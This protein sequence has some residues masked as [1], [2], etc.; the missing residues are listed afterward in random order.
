MN[1]LKANIISLNVGKPRTLNG[2]NQTIVTAIEKKSIDQQIFLAKEQ[3]DGD[4]QADKVHH[5]GPD[6]AVCVYSFNHYPY[7]EEKLSKKLSP[8]A[9]GEN[10]TVKGLLED[11]VHIGDLFRW[12]EAQVQ[13]S[14]PRKPCHK[15]AKRFEIP[16][17]VKQVSDSG[18]T[19]FYFRVIKEG[20]VSADTPL[21][22]IKRFSDVSLAEV[23]ETFYH[24]HS[25]EASVSRIASIPELADSWSEMMENQL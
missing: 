17:L 11:E 8:G 21:Q 19:G 5:G 10:L 1:R 4:E 2:L 9:F 22:F 23:N 20:M 25:D 13:I 6:K 18:Y 7:W 12:G 15:L 3:L 16:T 14:Q 24:K